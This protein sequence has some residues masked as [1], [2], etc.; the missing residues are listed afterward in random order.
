LERLLHLSVF[1][2][3]A[4]GATWGMHHFVWARL[5]R[6]TGL[7]RPWRRGLTALVVLLALSV[8]VAF[9]I[10]RNGGAA[11]L[12][13]P[14]ALAWSW[15]GFV[16]YAFL[17]GV[18]C[19]LA[20]RVVE[21]ARRR[22]GTRGAPNASSPAVP[23]VAQAPQDGGGV[24][25]AP[26]CEREVAGARSAERDVAVT[27]AVAPEAL[28]DR[29]AMLAR[30]VAGVVTVGAGCTTVAGRRAAVDL[31]T[32]EVEVK[33]ARLPR[34]LAGYR[35]VQLSDMHLGATLGGR[36]VQDVVA[37]A[38]AQRPDLVVIT[39]DLVDGSVRSLA[40]ELEQLGALKARHGTWF[41]TGNHEYYSGAEEWIAW[42]RG[43]GV[44]TLVNERVTIGDGGASFDLAG[45]PDRDARLFLPE[46]AIDLEPALRDR[47]PE[48]ELV[49]LAHR[50]VQIDVA[51]R[52]GAGLQ[53][54][55]HT[56]GGQMWPFGALVGLVEPYV[57]GLHRHDERTQI[58]V[59]RGTGFWGPPLRVGNPSEV[60][61]IVLT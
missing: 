56:H 46:H 40:R 11:G 49:L 31:T 8:A 33:L 37:V 52:H 48:R 53:L 17:I 4:L 10:R 13:G 2:A 44:R 39:G 50:P 26:R 18:V 23:A 22:S 59:S 61:R 41:V 35:I 45:V 15:F 36:F 47:D 32:P 6:D 21:L 28:L 20:W 42:L 60:T 55:G 34:A 14:S 5:V 12:W 57:A 3:L 30:S 19:E 27:T 1:L 38:N 58:Y 16:F 54:S 29:R 25:S 9:V 24:A 51:V 7:P 43:I